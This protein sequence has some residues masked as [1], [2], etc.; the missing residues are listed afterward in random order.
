[1]KMRRNCLCKYHIYFSF[2]QVIVSAVGCKPLLYVI[3]LAL[4]KFCGAY[5]MHVTTL[6][7]I[8]WAEVISGQWLEPRRVEGNYQQRDH[9]ATDFER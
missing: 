7:S 6:C 1:M 8:D 4:T 3:Q 2:Y 9:E 5:H